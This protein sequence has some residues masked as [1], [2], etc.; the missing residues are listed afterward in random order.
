MGFRVWGVSSSPG[1]YDPTPPGSPPSSACF[2]VP[3]SLIVL[4]SFCVSFG[5]EMMNDAVME[6]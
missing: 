2:G 5:S 4:L 6:S 1:R 3:W